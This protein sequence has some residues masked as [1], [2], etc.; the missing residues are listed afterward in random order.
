MRRKAEVCVSQDELFGSLAKK[1]LSSARIL[2]FRRPEIINLR[3]MCGEKNNF[4][5][6]KQRE[7]YFY[8]QLFMAF[9]APSTS[10]IIFSASA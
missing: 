6:R 1:F 7:K 5:N 8:V 3:S 9:R 4:G 2:K 10:R